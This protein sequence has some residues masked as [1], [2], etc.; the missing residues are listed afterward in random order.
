MKFRIQLNLSIIIMKLY[1]RAY[2]HSNRFY[3]VFVNN[4]YLVNNMR[5]SILWYQLYYSIHIKNVRTGEN[6][7]KNINLNAFI[8]KINLTCVPLT[9]KFS[10]VSIIHR[11]SLKN[12]TYFI[13]RFRITWNWDFLNFV[14]LRQVLG[15]F[16]HAIRIKF[17]SFKK[18]QN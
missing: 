17:P 4:H 10:S 3:Y 2:F 11:K 13:K 6:L 12:L 1:F 5:I 15:K 9:T 7:P 16:R 8:F 18:A 14:K